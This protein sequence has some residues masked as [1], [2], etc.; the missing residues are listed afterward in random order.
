MSIFALF[1]VTTAS[2]QKLMMESRNRRLS[3][4]TDK[5]FNLSNDLY[6]LNDEIIEENK[7]LENE[8]KEIINYVKKLNKK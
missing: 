5:Y 7:F 3:K 4:L 8:N 1:V 6:K 2:L